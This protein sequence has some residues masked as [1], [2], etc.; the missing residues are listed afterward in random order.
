M[1]NEVKTILQRILVRVQTAWTQGVLARDA[2]RN[3][4]DVWDDGA[5]TWCLLG[6]VEKELYTTREE[7]RSLITRYESR[8]ESV[9][10]LLNHQLPIAYS[11]LWLFN[12]SSKHQDVVDLVQRAID[13]CEETCQY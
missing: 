8:R 10:K 9:L 12:D 4:I 5:C 11:G 2:D 3:S 6:S 7:F 1:Q 13:A